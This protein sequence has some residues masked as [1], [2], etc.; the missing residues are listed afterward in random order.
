MLTFGDDFLDSFFSNSINPRQFD[1]DIRET[2]TGY[3][4][5][6]DL[7]GFKKEDLNV[8][9]DDNILTIEANHD[10]ESEEKN[11]DGTYLR[12]ERS[13]QSFRRQFIVKE[14]D[15]DGIRAKF[16]DGV[17]NLTLPKQKQVIKEST[18]IEIE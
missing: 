7:P 9:Y 14:I 13:S 17:L 8:G 16:E 1:V 11:E 10:E 2:D 4:L 18:R 3:E 6:A 12:R 15:K 5:K